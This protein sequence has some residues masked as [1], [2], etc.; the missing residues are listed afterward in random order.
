MSDRFERREK[1]LL[2]KQA[3]NECENPRKP[4]SGF[5]NKWSGKGP[6]K[7]FKRRWFAF[8]EKNGKLCFY[9]NNDDSLPLGEID[10]KRATFA[11]SATTDPNSSVFRIITGN[12]EYI[13]EANDRESC[14]YWLQELQRLRRVCVGVNTP[15]NNDSIPKPKPHSFS[16]GNTIFYDD[17]DCNTNKS[18]SVCGSATATLKSSC[19]PP[20]TR[21]RSLSNVFNRMQR[22]AENMMAPKRNSAACSKCKENEEKLFVATDDLMAVRHELQA[23]REVIKLLQ[24]QLEITLNEKEEFQKLCKSQQI[25]ED[26]SLNF[27]ERNRELITAK[28]KLKDATNEIEKLKSEREIFKNENEN[29]QQQVSMLQELLQAK[30][31]TVISLTNEVFDLQTEKKKEIKESGTKSFVIETS[32]IENLKDALKAYEI[33]NEFLNKEI[34][35]LNELRNINE[36]VQSDLQLKCYEWEAKCCQIQSKLL[37]LLKEIKESMRISAELHEPEEAALNNESIRTL[38]NRLLDESSLDIPLSWHPGNKPRNEVSNKITENTE[39]DDLG[40]CNR[41]DDD[42]VVEMLVNKADNLRIKTEE[43]KDP[44]MVKSFALWKSKWDTFVGNLGTNELQRSLELKTMLRSGVPQEYRCKIWRGLINIRVKQMRNQCEPNYY[45][46]LLSKQMQ[47]DRKWNIAGK[48]IELDLL[49]TLPNNKHFETLQSDGTSRLRRVLTAYSL[50]NPI[51]GYC[52]GMNRLAAVALL[53]MPEEDAF[54]ALVAIIERI[55]PR[56]YY[57]NNLLGAHVDQYVLRDLLMEKLPALHNHLEA[58]GVE[59]SFFSW[60]LTCFVDNIPVKIYLRVW[61][62]FL[63]EGSKVMFRFALAF[64]KYHEEEILKMNDAMSINQFMRCIG[65]RTHDVKLLCHIAFTVL[66]PFP[67]KKVKAKR[68]QY[69]SLVSNELQKL[70]EIRKSL[71]SHENRTDSQSD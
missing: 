42:D 51:V 59:I 31:E 11:L 25:S 14:I 18:D 57:T 21:Q 71:P 33:Q 26:L 28:V 50:H 20:S 66:N 45:Q 27:E 67:M 46:L 16:F 15:P 53:F 38:V 39:Y 56:E 64:L 17:V 62:V 55:M 58:H 23:S 6:L 43:L 24:Q 5:L 30:D 12:K 29:L 54:W 61:D 22:K 63:Y 49:R 60:F 2:S 7:G 3:L 4:V 34:V 8:N 52:Q 40:F 47:S 65:E 36:R 69:S 41:N 68:A 19:S 44:E 70:D 35:E 9:R 10:I 13:I 37:S 32:E 48:Q 1:S